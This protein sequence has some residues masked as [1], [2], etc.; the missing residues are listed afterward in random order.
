MKKNLKFLLILTILLLIACNEDQLVDSP[1]NSVYT[2]G[3]VGPAGGYIIY[4]AGNNSQGWQYIEVAKDDIGPFI[5][6]G[7]FNTPIINSRNAEIGSGMINTN[8]I[9]EFHDN[10]EDFYEK[11]EVC[12]DVSNG[13]VAAKACLD[14]D[15]EGF[16]DW[17]LP[18]IN[19][20]LLIYNELQV[21]GLGNFDETALYW[22]STEHDD[23]T[24]IAVDFGNGQFGYNCKQCAF[25]M[26][27][28]RPIRYF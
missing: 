9:V 15:I 14:L 25:D 13:T 10:L 17:Q 11:P 27:K 8:E 24:A 3:N 12:S 23:N 5:E 16:N 26:V 19:E 22:S 28:I 7:C 2:V 4:D 20:L 18:A 6:W 1:P 21:N